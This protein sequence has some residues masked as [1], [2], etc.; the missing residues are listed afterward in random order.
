MDSASVLNMLSNATVQ[1]MRE[2][3]NILR[4]QELKALE[5]QK[6]VKQLEKTA[7]EEA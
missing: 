7:R 1:E 2:W 5:T 3:K 6:F 4:G